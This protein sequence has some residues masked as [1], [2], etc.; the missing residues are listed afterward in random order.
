MRLRP[1]LLAAL[2]ASAMPAAA[3]PADIET[4]GNK[5]VAQ[6][7]DN[8]EVADQA[9]SKREA[10]PP[11]AKPRSGEREAG[12]VRE[13]ASR[14]AMPADTDDFG[15]ADGADTA[16]DQAIPDV[17]IPDQKSGMGW[18]GFAML[19]AG[20]LSLL[21]LLYVA[22]SNR[23]R[24]IQLE[25]KQ[26]H[27]HDLAESLLFKYDKKIQM[28]IEQLAAQ[29]TGK[30]TLASER[31]RTQPSSESRRE[32]APF[33]AAD[34]DTTPS[35][36]SFEP[37]APSPAPLPFRGGELNSL[38]ERARDMTRSEFR[39][40]AGRLG[41][42][43]DIRLEAEGA[44]IYRGEEDG[45]PRSLIGIR[46]DGRGL[47]L[48]PS[49]D[50]IKNFEHQNYKLRYSEALLPYFELRH[51]TDAVLRLVVPCIVQDEGMLL[52]VLHKGV[53]EGYSD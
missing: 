34:I 7:R 28:L 18:G 19:C 1:V 32:P 6:L 40:E 36:P 17:P 41:E 51:S 23:R 25:L 46:I 31:E 38:V 49:Q 37:I 27:D 42:L 16:Y 3:Q 50:Y 45:L 14:Q 13:P 39:E 8:P 11:R 9:S 53:L 24:I 5:P 15:G 26:Q 10:T 43:T 4:I 22:M 2:L 48:I 21:G 30:D 47:A 29:N 44:S 52:K 20:F 35:K 12:P 33:R